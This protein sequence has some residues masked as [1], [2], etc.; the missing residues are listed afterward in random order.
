TTSWKRTDHRSMDGHDPKCAT[1]RALPL[2]MLLLLQ[3]Q[4][5]LYL[6]GSVCED[7]QI[8]FNIR[9]D[10]VDMFDFC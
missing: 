4:F 6:I 2:P 3:L 9:L 1:F 5:P 10:A 8:G 7:G